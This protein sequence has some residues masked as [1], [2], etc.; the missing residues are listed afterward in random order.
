MRPVLQ[1]HC[2]QEINR[3]ISRQYKNNAI[4]HAIARLHWRVVSA[5][6]GISLLGRDPWP[7]L[8]RTHRLEGH[9]LNH[10]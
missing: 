3:V 1:G 8:A 10:C 9:F 7:I 4:I 2:Y 5:V 6:H